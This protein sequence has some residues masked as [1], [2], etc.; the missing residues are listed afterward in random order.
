MDDFR[1]KIRYR[2]NLINLDLDS[3]SRAG[4]E[5][6]PSFFEKSIGKNIELKKESNL[7]KTITQSEKQISQLY[8]ER[9]GQNFTYEK[10]KSLIIF[11][12]RLKRFFFSPSSKFLNKF[13]FL[14][15]KYGNIINMNDHSSLGR[16]INIG[17]MMYYSLNSKRNKEDIVRTNTGE[18]YLT[19]SKN[20]LSVPSKDV[21]NNE[22]Y[23]VKFLDKN[24]RRVNK[25]LS[26]RIINQNNQNISSYNNLGT[27]T[28][29]NIFPKNL[30]D[31]L[32]CDSNMKETLRN[33]YSNSKAND[34]YNN[35]YIITPNCQVNQNDI[36]N[37]NNDKMTSKYHSNKELYIKNFI[38]ERKIFEYVK[39][40]KIIKN[41]FTS[42]KNLY[43][44]KKFFIE[45][46]LAINNS[47][48][49]KDNQSDLIK[50]LQNTAATTTMNNSQKLKSQKSINQN[51]LLNIKTPKRK[52]RNI[53][54]MN[55][56]KEK[57]FQY[58]ININNNIKQLDTYAKKC[59]SFL[60][61][62]LKKNDTY[63]RKY[64]GKNRIIKDKELEKI[65]TIGKHSSSY[66]KNKVNEEKIQK[67]KILINDNF[68]DF[69]INKLLKGENDENNK[70][71]KHNNINLRKYNM[72]KENLFY[73][74]SKNIPS[75]T[76]NKANELL[77]EREHKKKMKN[78]RMRKIREHF[79]KN[80]KTIIKLKNL[81]K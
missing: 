75:Q 34:N 21:V 29:P 48:Q 22:F 72:M 2:N 41:K 26:N 80:V 40:D 27:M 5:I 38:T 43:N 67:M 53:N 58:K 77:S 25:I 39:K 64:N 11:E 36:S 33:D 55:L 47:Q 56:V 8:Y 59:N 35:Y 1:R 62:L 45:N 65:L 15:K 19:H 42:Y 54:N 44:P 16:R 73:R 20:F 60:L 37:K 63:N 6:Y 76:N 13:P 9:F 81:L 46:S 18:K 52:S 61:K 3:A 49:N 69:D 12:R 17:T 28:E 66:N 70:T 71:K 79:K 32:K 57:T 31:G 51:I 24:L 30:E 78:E 10:P 68:L 74:D 23:R 50:N 4:T 7:M 14:H